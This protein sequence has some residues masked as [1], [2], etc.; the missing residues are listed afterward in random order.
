MMSRQALTSLRKQRA[1]T[2]PLARENSFATQ[3][4]RTGHAGT[5]GMTSMTHSGHSKQFVINLAT[6]K[7]LGLEVPATLLARADGD[8][9]IWPTSAAGAVIRLH[10]DLEGSEATR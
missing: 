2:G 1:R 7:A 10:V 4:G 6:A 9:I 5:A 8:R 3:S